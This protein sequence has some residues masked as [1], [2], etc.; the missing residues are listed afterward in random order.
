MTY[1]L[2][3]EMNIEFASPF[4][5]LLKPGEVIRGELAKLTFFVTN[6]GRS[7][8]PGGKVRNWR[9]DFGQAH[10][11]EHTS[12]TANVKCKPIPPGEKIRL[13]SEEIVPLVEGLAW[14]YF[15]I[16]PEGEKKEEIHYY[17]SLKEYVA[18][19]EWIYCFYVVD[20]Q[21]VQLTSSIDELVRKIETL[22]G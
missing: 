12:A 2:L 22:R 11:I 20:R 17:Q 15:S 10:D 1:K 3:I 16:E 7:I 14:V 18:G 5:S 13:L 9:I 21:M 8:F 4:K 6:L 19:N